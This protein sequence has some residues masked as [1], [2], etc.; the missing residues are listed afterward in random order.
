M[1]K[2]KLQQKLGELLALAERDRIDIR[3]EISQLR[4]KISGQDDPA[5]QA[6]T[7]VLKARETERPTTL[8]LIEAMTES[9]LELHGDRTGGDDPALI[10]GIGLL[11]GDPVTFL[12]HQKG[13]NLKENI[14]HNYGMAHPAGYR[15]AHRLAIQAEKFGRPVITL[16]DTPG[17]YPGI[18]SERG[19]IAAAI[20][21]NLKLFSSL[22]VPIISIVFGEGGSGGALGIGVGDRI[23]MLENAIYSVISPEGCASILLKDSDQA[24]AAAGMLKLTADDLTRFGIID[25]IILEPEG[26]AER[27]HQAAA[28]AIKEVLLRELAEL[29]LL[30]PAQLV[31][32]RTR[33]LG[34]F[35]I[36]AEQPGSRMETSPGK[37][38]NR[39]RETISSHLPSLPSVSSN[40]EEEKEDKGREDSR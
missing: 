23:Y 9:F 16:I 6:W 4:E 21:A 29:R 5:G 10:G 35:G 18:A 32:N 15:K 19:G 11:S 26:G 13:R 30:S 7:R 24:P 28:A 40:P 38:W 25:G 1:K 27:D 39:M 20:A 33:R 3:E 8:D 22:Q 2:K 37:W 31:K 34:Q 17:A 14:H 12:G 36:F